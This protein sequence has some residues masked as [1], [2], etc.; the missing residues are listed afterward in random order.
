M[1]NIKLYSKVLQEVPSKN[2]NDDFA[3]LDS[4]L[5]Q[6]YCSFIICLGVYAFEK[7]AC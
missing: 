6:S 2:G 4:F 5:S 7:F 1:P 3:V